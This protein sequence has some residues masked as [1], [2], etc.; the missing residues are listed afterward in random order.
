MLTNKQI[1]F[2]R[3]KAHHLTPIVWLGEKGLSQSALSEILNQL[4]THELIK[5]RLNPSGNEKKIVVKE[6]V[7]KT[8]SNYVNLIGK[9]VIIYKAA[10]E[11]KILIPQN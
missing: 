1:K 6:I 4:S 7:N 3:A 2:L 11:P 10:E 8:N 9:T 5:I